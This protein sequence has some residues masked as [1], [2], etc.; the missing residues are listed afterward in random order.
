[1][2]PRC[3]LCAALGLLL[4]AG[5]QGQGVPDAD[6]DALLG[7]FG[8]QHNL[9]AIVYPGLVE[10]RARLNATMRS[11]AATARRAL[12][13]GSGTGTTCADVDA[14]GRLEFT[15]TLPDYSREGSPFYQC[16]ALVTLFLPAGLTTIG[17]YAFCDC[18]SLTS[19]EFPA[20]LTTIGSNAFYGCTG[21]TSVD[22]PAG[23]TTIGDR[24]FAW[25]TGLTS[26]E[27]PAGLTT[28]GDY[29]FYGC[30]GL[31]SVELP[32]GL[33]TIGGSA[34]SSCTGLTSVE[35]PA[36]LTTIGAYAFNGCTGL[37]SVDFPA[38]LTTIGSNAFSGCT[39]LTNVELPAGLTTIGGRV[40][41]ECT[42]LTSV[43]YCGGLATNFDTPVT[44]NG[45]VLGLGAGTVTTCADVDANG[46]LEVN[47]TL[48]DYSWNDSPFYQCAALVTLVLPAGL[49]IIGYDS[50]SGCTGLTNVE[51]PAGL[52]TIGAGAFYG[53]TGLT[54]VELPAGLTTIGDDAFW[55]CTG[56]TS[57]D[58][59]AG[60]TTIGDY[61]FYG[62]TGLTSVELPA[63]LTTIGDSAFYG[64]TGLTS[65]EFPA[66]LTTI[67][68]DSFYWC[69]GLTTYEL[70]PG[71]THMGIRISRIC[72]VVF[73][74]GSG[75]PNLTTVV[76]PDTVETIDPQAFASDSFQKLTIVYCGTAPLE[77]LPAYVIVACPNNCMEGGDFYDAATGN[78]NQCPYAERCEGGKCVE[79]SAGASCAVCCTESSADKTCPS[80]EQWYQAGQSCV[81]CG[82][83]GGMVV[84]WALGGGAIALIVVLV[85]KISRVKVDEDGA[86]SNAAQEDFEDK[87]DKAND[88]QEA[89]S[90]VQRLGNASLV[91]SITIPFAQF[92]LLAL[93]LPFRFPLV[94]QQFAEWLSSFIN[95]DFG[96]VASPECSMAGTDASTIMMTKFVATHF[97]YIGVNVLLVVLG[98]AKSDKAHAFNAV[99]ATF[100]LA[101]G[102]LVRSCAQ[103]LDCSAV[104]FN[105]TTTDRLDVNPAVECTSDDSTFAVMAV[106]ATIGFVAYGFLIPAV[107]FC[108]MRSGVK[109]GGLE[110]PAFLAS[111]A[112]VILKYRPARWWFEFPLL[113]YK[114]FVIVTAVLLNSAQNAWLLLAAH[115]AA[116]G[117]LLVLVLLTK[118]YVT[119][120]ANTLQLVAAGALLATYGVGGACLALD[121]E[122]NTSAGL[123]LAV[124]VFEALLL[125]GVIVI[126]VKVAK[127]SSDDKDDFSGNQTKNPAAADDSTE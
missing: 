99:T 62:C 48:P 61:A 73:M 26:V 102:A 113:A 117:G 53:C 36:G 4:A 111:A 43:E 97:V 76:L 1:M 44:C 67:G 15:G 91:A 31:T 109:N 3:L 101:L 8:G 16:A 77:S 95:I 39:G 121:G 66:G 96:Q 18:R 45:E 93:H 118:P 6:R 80:G 38:G 10:E 40:F 47:G 104:A 22:F 125:A 56:L 51:L 105:G 90:V 110:D 79:G 82:A 57:V 85:W 106:V 12:Q 103:R 64:C 27:L 126:G 84:G 65:V 119:P 21:L 58:F 87:R 78:C 41:A 46:R 37:T 11:A 30:T 25:C 63:G 7:A 33:T 24:A 112:W 127:N 114:V 107:L 54:S 14:N 100:T 55:A 50:F 98:K 75:C 120:D 59:P 94:L 81:K 9:T 74:I 60:L 32:A 83:A 124:I 72:G 123:E 20:G 42:G 70:L 108:R 5:A 116:T 88:A 29:A 92:S 52:T 35:L 122:C 19:V 68:D 28:I 2:L 69:T 34:F 86:V 89:A 23:L 49:T 71:S 13:S 17:D 115:V